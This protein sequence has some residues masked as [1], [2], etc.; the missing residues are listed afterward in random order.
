MSAPIVQ[1][2]SFSVIFVLWPKI[3]LSDS[4]WTDLHSIPLEWMFSFFLVKKIKYF[5]FCLH[6]TSMIKNKPELCRK[7]YF[8]KAK[9]MENGELGNVRRCGEYLTFGEMRMKRTSVGFYRLMVYLIRIYWW[10]CHLNAFESRRFWRPLLVSFWWKKALKRFE[11][12]WN[13]PNLLDLNC[14]CRIS[15]LLQLVD[16][17]NRHS[18]R[19]IRRRI[20]VGAFTAQISNERIRC[21][22]QKSQF[23]KNETPYCASLSDLF[24]K[25]T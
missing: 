16:S 3:E 20:N 6:S 13:I 7:W 12:S 14:F 2:N 24:Q 5:I 15:E 11:L 4:L 22:F 18:I 21:R 19:P 1:R 10:W 8:V 25:N 9:H 23:E 17:S